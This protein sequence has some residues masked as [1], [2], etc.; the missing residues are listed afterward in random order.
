MDQKS[1]SEEQASTQEAEGTRH[2][3]RYSE[4][5]SAMRF[6]VKLPV[7][8]HAGTNQCAAETSNISANGV[9]F[10]VDV[11]MPVG[12]PV[13][14]TISMPADVVGATTDVQVRCRGRVVRCNVEGE[15]RSVG[16]VIDEY[17]FERV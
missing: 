2:E 17:S 14:F 4:M 5:Q 11:D 13:E 6:P 16:A 15:H 1:T 3:G 7:S 8:V 10:Q 9:L 12:S